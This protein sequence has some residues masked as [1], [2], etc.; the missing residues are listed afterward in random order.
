MTQANNS[1]NIL[2]SCVTT[3]APP[4]GPNAYHNKVPALLRP[5]PQVVLTPVTQAIPKN[6]NPDLLLLAPN[7]GLFVNTAGQ[8]DIN[9]AIVRKNLDNANDSE[10]GMEADCSRQVTWSISPAQ[11]SQGDNL[12]LSMA[13]L[14]PYEDA[15]IVLT[16]GA[17]KQ[18]IWDVVADKMGK[19]EGAKLR[20]TTGISGTYKVTPLVTCA[21][22]MPLVETFEAITGNEDVVVLCDGNVTMVPSFGATSIKD[23][24]FGQ[25]KIIVTSTHSSPVANVALAWTKLPDGLV[26]VDSSSP[27]VE[28]NAAKDEF[29]INAMPSLPANGQTT[30]T[31]NFKGV[32]QTFDDIN[33]AL[34]LV[35]GTGSYTCGGNGYQAGGG[36]TGNLT[37][38]AG[39]QLINKLVMDEFAVTGFTN[40]AVTA[41]TS[42]TFTLKIRNAGNATL[43]Q[44]AVNVPLNNGN[45]AVTTNPANAVILASGLTL[46][47]G[48][49]HTVTSV[50]SFDLASWGTT[51]SY[52][53]TINVNAAS[54]TGKDRNNKVV[55][56]SDSLYTDFTLNKA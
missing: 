55:V 46:A 40:G 45:S 47:P 22:M 43:T 26:G 13:G 10:A 35:S 27:L 44:V 31:I 48:D 14:K 9:W 16:Y 11:V 1:S 6:Q 12:T 23:G 8:L 42:L 15:K 54:V 3:Q 29:R 19:V 49:T 36:S 4:L 39:L 51:T 32:N 37:I 7:S 5:A 34:K 20:I 56:A 28:F 17:G 30:F 24:A 41:G 18:Y 33:A 38:L 2:P 50:A 52:K 53:H 21:A 25:L